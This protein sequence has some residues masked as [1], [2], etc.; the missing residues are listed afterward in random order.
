MPVKRKGDY[1]RVGRNVYYEKIYSS[2]L[3]I[4]RGFGAELCDTYTLVLLR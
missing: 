4:F 2:D 3:F 1:N